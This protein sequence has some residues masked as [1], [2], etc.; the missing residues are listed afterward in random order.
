MKNPEG[1]K[2]NY[3]SLCNV[4]YH[5]GDGGRN[6]TGKD[7]QGP[8]F[9]GE[10]CMKSLLLSSCMLCDSGLAIR[11]AIRIMHQQQH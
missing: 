2:E 9:K 5:I 7:M 6:E 10:L 4:E 3:S 1:V 8:D 11:R